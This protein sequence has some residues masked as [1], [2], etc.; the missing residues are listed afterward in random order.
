M[1]AV[2]SRPA[3]AAVAARAEGVSQS[4]WRALVD[5]IAELEELLDDLREESGTLAAMNR[6]RL[7]QALEARRNLLRVS[8]IGGLV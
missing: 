6:H 7:L 4:D 8:D 5:E 2:L 3:D 1:S